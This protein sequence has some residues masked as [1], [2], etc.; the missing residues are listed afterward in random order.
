MIWIIPLD[1]TSSKF[2]LKFVTG[3]IVE[4]CGLIFLTYLYGSFDKE[5]FPFHFENLKSPQ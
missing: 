2:F 1:Y 5:I 4:D 3:A